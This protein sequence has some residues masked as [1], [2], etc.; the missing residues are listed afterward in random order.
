LDKGGL[1]GVLGERSFPNGLMTCF[2]AGPQCLFDG[3]K[4]SEGSA[5]AFIPPLRRSHFRLLLAQIAGANLSQVHIRVDPGGVIVVEVELDRVVPHWCSASDLDDILAMNRKGIGRD[6]YRRRR[7]TAC[8]T[9][10][11]LAQIGVGIGSFVP[12]TPFDEH[13]TWGGQ[14]DASRGDVHKVSKPEGSRAEKG[15]LPSSFNDRSLWS[16]EV[17]NADLSG[18]GAGDVEKRFPVRSVFPLQDGRV[19]AITAGSDSRI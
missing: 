6:F 9:R 16:I 2:D 3:V 11:T 19:A 12:V 8:G 7:V 13:T 18:C 4:S 15:S 1:Q 17:R 5:Q 14:L 10:T